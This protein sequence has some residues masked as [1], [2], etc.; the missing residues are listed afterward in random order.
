[1][2][3]ILFILFI[4][5][6]NFLNA[7]SLS[8]T[9]SVYKPGEDI[10]IKVT[11]LEYHP[12]NWIAIYPKRA[13]SAGSNVI[14][15][16]W[17]KETTNGK[18]VFKT[19]GKEFPIPYLTKGAYEAR[20]MYNNSYTPEA[21]V[22]FYVKS[23]NPPGKVKLRSKDLYELGEDIIIEVA[24]LE[25]HPKNWIAIYPKGA[26]SAG[27]NVIRWKWT[28]ETT[29]GE[30]T[31]K[32]VG[33]VITKPYLPEGVYEA[34]VMYNNSYIPESSVE[35][36]VTGNNAD[37]HVKT[38]KSV[39]LENEPIEIEVTNTPTTLSK[40]YQK[41]YIIIDRKGSHRMTPLRMEPIESHKSKVS[42]T[43]R[44]LP[45]GEYYLQLILPGG[46]KKFDE[47]TFSVVK[48]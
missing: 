36:A 35:F 1:M 40:N 3:R 43:V 6:L 34:R 7:A 16:K 8:S 14:R 47:Y 21:V 23:G 32:T 27:S 46:A 41:S 20:V 22:D 37:T 44:A 17:T 13:S 11:D 26:S 38:T 5:S 39:F 25:Y 12:N 9:K 24:D 30:F 4:I 33:K 10:V 45:V 29:D 48:K 19:V 15:W 18:F 31:F 2:K 28:K 42:L